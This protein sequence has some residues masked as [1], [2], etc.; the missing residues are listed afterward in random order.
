[1]YSIV[2]FQ[3]KMKN[4]PIYFVTLVSGLILQNALVHSVLK[5]KSWIFCIKTKSF[6]TCEVTFL[7]SGYHKSLLFI[8]SNHL[9]SYVTPTLYDLVNSL[10]SKSFS[11]WISSIFNDSTEEYGK[12]WWHDVN[13]ETL[14]FLCILWCTCMWLVTRCMTNE[15]I[16]SYQR[17]A[18]FECVT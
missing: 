17:G 12:M 8:P 7:I 14:W 6:L 18:V 15:V 9:A 11:V 16:W 1:M 3:H 10:L 4:L 5:I 13:F 2:K